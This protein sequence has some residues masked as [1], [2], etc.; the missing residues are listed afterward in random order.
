MMFNDNTS[1]DQIFTLVV[2]FYF[3]YSMIHKNEK[4]ADIFR[5]HKPSAKHGRGILINSP[6]LTPLPPM[7]EYGW[8]V[9]YVFID[10]QYVEF[11]Y[12]DNKPKSIINTINIF[13]NGL[14]SM[15]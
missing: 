8:L 1:D 2:G 9:L 12:T 15:D 14:I 7:N 6:I 5:T 4:S 10:G 11:N 3:G 13:E